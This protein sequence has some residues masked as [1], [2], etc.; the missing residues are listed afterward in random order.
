MEKI[1][2]LGTGHAMTLEC[3]NTCFVLQNNKNKHFLVDTGGGNGVLKQL[4]NANIDINSIHDVFISH[5]HF[6]HMVGVF[7]IVRAICSNMHN[8]KYDSNLRIYCDSKIAK[9]IK[10]FVTQSLPEDYVKHFSEN[11][12]F[13]ILK[14]NQKLN[15]IGYD[16]EILDLYSK[17]GSQFGFQLTLEN[18]KKL[19]FLGD[20]PC[21]KRLYDLIKNNDWILHEALCLYSQKDIF[22]PYEKFHSTVKDVCESM[23]K[24]GIKNLVLW[25]SED[26]NLPNRKKLYTKEAKEYFDGNVYVPND[27]EVINLE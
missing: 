2:V 22:K 21:S 20:V 18:N 5:N 14:N 13:C 4:K 6:D 9:L 8:G 12:L 17:E 11:V 26:K 10:K 23:S 15:I 3:Y 25:H 24:L 27:L 7:W 1:I 16:I 19:A